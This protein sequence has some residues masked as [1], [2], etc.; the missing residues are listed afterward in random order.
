MSISMNH[1]EFDESLVAQAWDQ[2]ANV[3]A[4]HV[5]RGWDVYREYFNNPAFFSFTGDVHGKD[6][7]D[8]GCGEGTT[9]RQLTRI[10]AHVTGID[11]SPEMIRLAQ[12][13][14]RDA[15]LGI[16]YDVASF[17]N[18]AGYA[19]A[20][21]DMVVSF[22]A[23][24]DCPNLEQALHELVRVL[25]PGGDIVFSILHP[26][27]MTK[28]FGWI[29]DAQTGEQKLTVAR[30]F[31]DRP[32]VERWRFSKGD[33]PQDAP[34]FVVPRFHHPISAYLNLLVG[35]GCVIQKLEEPRP[36]EDICERHPWLQRW[37]DHAAIYLYVRARKRV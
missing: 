32:T 6:V 3:W 18:L 11:L 33:A 34:L 8:A 25:R 21:F 2:N 24:M 31:D 36:S 17:T 20:S 5:R 27:F 22:M 12:Q 9:T 1:S 4:E 30:Y 14:E 10:G 28:G 13:A 29:E 15:P 37:R 23:L 26:C 35:A 19:D 7:L 16:R